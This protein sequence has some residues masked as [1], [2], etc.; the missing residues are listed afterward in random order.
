M[1]TEKPTYRYKVGRSADTRGWLKH[2]WWCKEAGLMGSFRCSP[3]CGRPNR[4][5]TWP[6]FAPEEKTELEAAQELLQLRAEETCAVCR[7]RAE[8]IV[9]RAQ[10]KK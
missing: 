7:T 10:E 2:L 6:A 9:K 8:G 3:V 1:E 4:H 5:T